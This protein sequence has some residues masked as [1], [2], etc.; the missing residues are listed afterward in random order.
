MPMND[1][2]NFYTRYDVGEDDLSL[3]VV[4]YDFHTGKRTY[5]KPLDVQTVPLRGRYDGP[6]TFSRDTGLDAGGLNGF[7]QAALDAAWDM[8]LRP[9][10]HEGTQSELTAVR[11]HLADMRK[12]AKVPGA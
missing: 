8:G 2:W 5:V 11:S 10:G 1:G 4:H 7:M 12:L 3:F 9:K 6:A